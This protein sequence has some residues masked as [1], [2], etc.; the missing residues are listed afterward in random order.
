VL[1]LLKHSLLLHSR[2]SKPDIA[3]QLKPEMWKG[4]WIETELSWLFDRGIDCTFSTG[5]GDPSSTDPDD[6]G[7]HLFYTSE[8]R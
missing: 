1:Q 5:S 3:E 2:L 6:G 8:R 4:Y 7:T